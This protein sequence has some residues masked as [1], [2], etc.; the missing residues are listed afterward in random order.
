MSFTRPAEQLPPET[1]DPAMHVFCNG[2]L[3]LWALMVFVGCG[4]TPPAVKTPPMP[5]V[6]VSQP[7]A[8]EVVDYEDFI[9]RTDAVSRVEIR[10]RVSGY[11]VKVSFTDGDIVKQGDLLYEIDP[12]PFQAVL[13]QAKGDVERLEAEAKLLVIQVDRY[14][15]LV[16]KGAASQQDLDEYLGKQASNIGALK[17]A[18]A[19][20]EQATLN[21]DFT[22]ITAPITGQISRTLLTVGNLVIADN[23]LLTTVVSID[24]MY[25]YLDIE[26]PTMLRIRKLIREGVIEAR[27]THEVKVHMGLADDVEGKFPLQGT[28][29]FVNNML[30]PQTGTIQI[31]GRFDNPYEF[32]KQPPVLTPGMF[33]RVRLPMGPLHRVL[34]VTERA[35]GTDQGEKY[36]Y[37]VDKQNKVSYRRVTLGLR[38]DGLRAIENGLQPGERVV[39]NGLQRVRPGIEVKVEPAEM[40]TLAAGTHQPSPAGKTKSRTNDE[41]TND[42]GMAGHE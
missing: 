38:F 2:L 17:A 13:D 27:K 23:T 3:C 34:L 42:E 6:N 29:D 28:I 40:H 25:A 5:V 7:I 1:D 33:V 4:P 12:R 8:K 32:P 41:R 24:P 14:R 18:E 37:V 39:V 10:A 31:R 30:D 9:G 26:E 20:V 16:E 36:V 19:K 15:K 21:L 22:R 35:I 11:L